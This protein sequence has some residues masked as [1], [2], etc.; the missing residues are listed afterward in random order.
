M[1]QQRIS[2][3]TKR[4][5]FEFNFLT[6]RVHDLVSEAVCWFDWTIAGII[7]SHRLEHCVSSLNWEKQ[8]EL[9]HI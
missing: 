2:A 4:A 5:T 9:G 6:Q 1:L 8:S 3:E 7:V